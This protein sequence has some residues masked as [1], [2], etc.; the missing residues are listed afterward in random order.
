MKKKKISLKN[1]IYDNRF[2]LTLSI[3]AAVIIWI[4]VA[5]QASPEDDRI[6]KDVP[7]KIEISNNV[8]N[9]GLQMFGNTDFTVEVK[10]HGKRYDVAES[11]LTKDDISVVAKTNYVDSTGSQTLKLEVT[12]KDPNKANYEIVSLSQDSINV[13]FD[14]Y[15]EGEYT[16]QTDIIYDGASYVTNGLIAETPVLSANTVKLSGP[17]TEMVKIKK[18]V[19]RV[20]L[21]KKLSATTTLD[22]EIIPLSEYGGKLQYITVNDGIADITMTLPVYQRAE[23]PTTVTFKNAPAVADIDFYML[24]AGKNEITIDLTTLNGVKIMSGETKLK[25]TVEMSGV[26]SEKNSVSANNVS[27][28]NVPTGYKAV[29]TQTKIPSVEV[30]GPESELKKI[31]SEQLFAEVDLSNADPT[32]SHGTAYARAYVKDSNNC[33]VH[34]RYTVSY[35]L[36]KVQ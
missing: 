29:L 32:R 17:V 5:I 6:V 23:L 2:V 22:A 16:L 4:V 11:V 25:V 15:K 33:W 12:P 35:R 21:N 10:V 18:V 19:A 13:Y 1:L 30:V 34:N 36:E 27:F 7:V 14:Y 3:I 8:S 20:T 28:I 31:S 9:L 26:T 24:G